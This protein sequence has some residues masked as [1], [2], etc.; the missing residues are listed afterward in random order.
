M[1][2]LLA[3]VFAALVW[4]LH[5]HPANT[6]FIP[7]VAPKYHYAIRQAVFFVTSLV[8]GCYLI[9]ISNKYTYLAVM[10]QSPSIGCLWIWSVVEMDLSLSLLSLA[11]AY[12]Y[13]WQGG[14]KL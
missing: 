6:T 12:V 4:A 2:L 3:T 13:F 11:G 14:Y 8:A 7:G 10:K 9:H 5:P 1:L